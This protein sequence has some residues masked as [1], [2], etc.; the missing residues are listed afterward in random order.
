MWRSA[1]RRALQ[2]AWRAESKNLQSCYRRTDI[3]GA[4]LLA[5]QIFEADNSSSQKI[6]IIYSDMLNSTAELNLETTTVIPRFSDVSW[7]LPIADLRAVRVSVRGVD[8]NGKT[9]RYWN[10]VKYFWKEYFVGAGTV[11]QDYSPL[12]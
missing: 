7:R 11:L 8:G 3:L 1:A 10:A 12:R 9:N 6:L 4:L 2:A 5:G